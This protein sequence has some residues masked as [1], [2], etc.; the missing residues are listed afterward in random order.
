MFNPNFTNAVKVIDSATSK[1]RTIF[2]VIEYI[3]P[4]KSSTSIQQ[5]SINQPYNSSLGEKLRQVRISLNKSSIITQPGALQFMK[6][7]INM[8]LKSNSSSAVKGFFKSVGTGE[9][10]V[11]PKYTGEYGEIYLEPAF[12]YFYILE[13]ENEQ[14]ILDDGMFYC[15]DESIQLDVY[16]NSAAAGLFG[17]DGFRQPLLKGSGVAI[18]ES[19]VPFDEIL[20]YQLNNETLKIDGKFAI[21]VRGNI[22]IKIEKSTKS[23]L[24]SIRSGEGLLQTYTG[25][26]EVWVAPGKFIKPVNY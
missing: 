2:E 16:T 18:L 1:N 8:E 11:T 12:K 17:G 14:L 6:G 19:D 22:D 5:Q 25:T 23:T 26:G 21:V 4:R 24:G 13:I 10:S 20:I 9:S 15:C 3:K 7:P